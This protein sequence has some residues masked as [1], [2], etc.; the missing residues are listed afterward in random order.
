MYEF[1]KYMGMDM[2]INRFFAG[3]L[4]VVLLLGMKPELLLLAAQ[5]NRE[6]EELIRSE[7]D[8]SEMSYER[9]EDTEFKSI[10]EKI[11][12]LC[13]TKENAKE[14]LE[15]FESLDTILLKVC[16]NS[17]LIQIYFYQDSTNEEYKEE[18][19][20]MTKLRMEFSDQYMMTG[21]KILNSPC[22][23]AAKEEWEEEAIEAFSEYEE[24]TAEE[25]R[26]REKET[27]LEQ[28]YNEA[29]LETDVF[30]H[31]GKSY[32]ETELEDL[33]YSGEITDEQYAEYY[34]ELMKNKNK[35]LSG[36]FLDLVSVRTELAKMKGY[37]SYSDY[38]YEKVYDRDFMPDDLKKFREQVKEYIVPVYFSLMIQIYSDTENNKIDDL[39]YSKDTLFSYMETYLPQIREEFTESWDYMIKYNLYDLDAYDTKQ[40]VGF[41]TQINVENVPF[42]FNYPNESFYDFKTVVHEFGH[43][44]SMFHASKEEWD[45]LYSN[46]DLSEIH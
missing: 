24:L 13:E 25:E 8:F 22:A 43:Y 29:A 31:E 45:G 33:Y 37:G 6:E 11:N 12:I 40:Q 21:K 30:L 7:K 36:Y 14:V 1:A 35:R 9:M 46:L 32:K 34:S 23:E 28:K 38:A 26:L 2:K 19:L 18:E 16:R 4:T 44:N 17:S 27:T 42:M 10:L 20:Y 5:E 3:I 39:D 41:T 15:L